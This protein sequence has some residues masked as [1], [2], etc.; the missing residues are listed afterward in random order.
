MKNHR[1]YFKIHL[2]IIII[3]CLVSC[4]KINKDWKKISSGSNYWHMA[5][6][7][8]NG[9]LWLS[10]LF[11]KSITILSGQVNKTEKIIQI[12]GGHRIVDIC[13]GPEMYLLLL[14]EVDNL[15]N[16][17]NESGE[18]GNNRP[19][20]MEKVSFCYQN[21]GN[22]FFVGNSQIFVITNDG[23]WNYITTTKIGIVQRVYQN[24]DNTIFVINKLGILFQY[25]E[26]TKTWEKVIDLSD[27]G[28]YPAL[29]I[30][31]D[32]TIVFSRE[33]DLDKIYEKKNG[34]KEKIIIT[35]SKDELTTNII[36][37]S[38]EVF[39]IVTSKF[40]YS[41]KE[42]SIIKIPLPFG[43]NNIKT[44]KYLES[45]GRLYIATNTG[46]YYIDQVFGQLK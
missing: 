25:L 13:A 43:V 4:S 26:S 20:N 37:I 22:L 21:D 23:S 11:G 19:D 46:V 16:F 24:K 33:D 8:Q 27:N 42:D 38:D 34:E 3:S 12:P 44:S 28:N 7:E 14:G 15:L 29:L 45:I 18:W 31:E 10:D 6:N 30:Y 39:L 1:Y 5:V 17:N 9:D 36:W 35:L 32:K 40:I 2:L 41:Y